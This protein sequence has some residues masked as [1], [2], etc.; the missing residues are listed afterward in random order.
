MAYE[1]ALTCIT[2]PAAADLS[3]SQFCFVYQD[4]N[5]RAALAGEG[6][7]AIGVLQNKPA[8]QDREA[9][10]AIA[11]V[12]KVLCGG[13]IT[14]GNPVSVG[15]NG[16]ATAVG[17]SDDQQMGVARAAGAANRIIPMLIEKRGLS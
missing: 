6:V 9:R 4:S 3:A 12:T 10:I 11:G 5:G 1:E 15:A 2:M 17:S 7:R 8:A 16:K 14:S 13:S